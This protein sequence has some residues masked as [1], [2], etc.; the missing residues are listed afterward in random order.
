[1]DYDTWKTT[2]PEQP[3]R[4]CGKECDEWYRCPE[5]GSKNGWCVKL[6]EYTEEGDSVC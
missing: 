5:E 1:M 2:A 6:G 3:E 4:V